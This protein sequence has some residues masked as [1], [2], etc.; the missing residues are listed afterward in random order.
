M[1]AASQGIAHGH[2][3]AADWLFLIA[4]VFF[5]CDGLLHFSGRTQT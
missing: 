2:L 4:A 3:L 1:I 5:L